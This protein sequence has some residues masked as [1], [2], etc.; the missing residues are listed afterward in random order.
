MVKKV[1]MKLQSDFL[2]SPTPNIRIGGLVGFGSIA[3]E[4]D[5]SI[6]DFFPDFLNSLFKCAEDNDAKVRY[7]SSEALY[8]IVKAVRAKVLDYIGSFFYVLCHLYSDIDNDVKNI[9][10]FLISFLF[11]GPLMITV[12]TD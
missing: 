3:L 2:R 4:L 6:V 11:N 5:T 1:L 7:Y 8:N 10:F 9:S 12:P